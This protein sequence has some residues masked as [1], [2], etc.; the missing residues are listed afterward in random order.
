M[1]IGEQT[2]KGSDQEAQIL[3]IA[4]PYQRQL[5]AFVVEGEHREVN[6]SPY[7]RSSPVHLLDETPNAFSYYPVVLLLPQT[8]PQSSP[9]VQQTQVVDS[10]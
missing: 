4:Y 7:L 6:V 9:L 2:L 10:S 5:F 1:L 8:V 3:R